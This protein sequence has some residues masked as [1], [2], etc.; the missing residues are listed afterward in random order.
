MNNILLLII[1]RYRMKAIVTNLLVACGILLSTCGIFDAVEQT[2]GIQIKLINQMGAK[3]LLPTIDMIVV[4]YAIYGSSPS[5]DTFED[6]DYSGESVTI[7]SLRFGE[8]TVSVDGK[9]AAG[10]IIGHGD[11]N[12]V[13]H[14]DETSTVAIPVQPLPGTGM[15]DLTVNW[16]AADIDIPS[17]DSELVPPIGESQDIIFTHEGDS[18]ATSVSTGIPTGYHT[19][20]VKLLDNGLLTMGSVEVVRIVKAETTYG[21]FDFLDVN[22]PGGS[23]Q[24][25]IT[26]EMD[27]PLTVTIA[28]GV[29]LIEVGGSMTVSASVTESVGNVVYVWYVNGESVA[30]GDQHVVSGLEEGVYRLDV[31]TFTADG[32]RAG[33][34]TH[35]FQVVEG[36]VSN[37]LLAYY[38]FNGNANDESINENHGTL[39]GDVALTSDRFG[40]VGKAFSFDGSGDYIDCG[41]DVMVNPETA[42]TVSAWILLDAY[43]IS[44]NWVSIVNKRM[45][46][47]LQIRGSIGL[48][49][50]IFAGGST[51]KGI[52]R[53]VSPQTDFTLGE[54]YH[55]VGTYNETTTDGYLYIDGLQQSTEPN[56]NGWPTTLS[57]GGDN[58][59]IGSE[60]GLNWQWFDG[61]IDDIRIYDRALTD[62][63]VQ[64]LYQEGDGQ[65]VESTQMI[66][67]DRINNRL[68]KIDDMTGS[69]W[70]TFG[71]G[72]NGVNQFNEPR[73]LA[74][75]SSGRIYITDRHNHRVV[76]MDNFDGTGWTTYGGQFNYPV[77][78]AIDD[79]DRIYIGDNWN[80]RIVR[81][82]NMNGDGWV[83]FG[84]SGNGVNPPYAPR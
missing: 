34:A 38:P 25:N 44:G 30:T 41:N 63:E 59:Y 73:D 83:T 45:S 76:R 6:L 42:I 14:T 29:E 71:S 52:T 32:T 60:A 40:N 5:G 1:S 50:T 31:T 68:V 10:I 36:I 4:R 8:W 18:Q 65:Y 67:V 9:N 37:G 35:E 47:I 61:K 39:Y 84:T 62:I 27:D 13:V 77:G 46:Y 64:S 17:V 69:N 48:V 57:P 7:G 72:G 33:S 79:M 3:T 51:W 22:Q 24:V 55:V 16:H 74:T 82:D 78:I 43:P 66:I 21:T 2:G 56:Y 20:I 23:I 11:G 58:L 54:W 12:T 53:G 75:D 70:Q 19:L 28:G 49:L 80:H 81:F 26:P 15:L